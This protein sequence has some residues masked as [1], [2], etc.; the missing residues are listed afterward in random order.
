MTKTQ[1]ADRVTVNEKGIPVFVGRSDSTPIRATAE[2]LV[3][4]EHDILEESDLLRA[5]QPVPAMHSPNDGQSVTVGATV[6]SALE[7]LHQ[8]RSI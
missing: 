2:E 8:T 3:A 7:T 4:L 5:G 1:N 6:K